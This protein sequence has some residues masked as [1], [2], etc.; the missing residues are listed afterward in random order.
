[1]LIVPLR[2]VPSQKLSI[3]LANQLCQITLKTRWFGLYMDLSVND[4][5]IAAR[6]GLYREEARD[7]RA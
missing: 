4:S 5:P 2:A 6:L 7:V 1:M 3:L